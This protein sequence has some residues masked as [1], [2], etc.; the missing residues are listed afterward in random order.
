MIIKQDDVSNSV[1]QDVKQMDPKA[2]V[3]K[4]VAMAA[5]PKSEEEKPEVQTLAELLGVE[6]I[7]PGENY[8]DFI[9]KVKQ[10]T[11]VDV[12]EMETVAQKQE[13]QEIAMGKFYLKLSK[14]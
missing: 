2:T 9:D 11:G 7:Q 1:E 12:T 3:E 10:T 5:P 4:T 14:F 8:N 6:E 13:E